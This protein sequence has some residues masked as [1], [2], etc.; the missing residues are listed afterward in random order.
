MRG[1]SGVDNLVRLGD[2]PNGLVQ[3]ALHLWMEEHLRLLDQK[4]RTLLPP[5]LKRFENCEHQGVLDAFSE[6]CRAHRKG[7]FTHPKI[8]GLVKVHCV[9]RREKQVELVSV[10]CGIKSKLPQRVLLD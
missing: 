9:K 2:L 6:F 8:E 5:L 1:V 7:S 3:G 10:R 4:N